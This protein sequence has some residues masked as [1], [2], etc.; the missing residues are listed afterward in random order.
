MMTCPPYLVDWTYG[1]A[2]I[3]DG[4]VPVQRCD[5]CRVFDGDEAAATAAMDDLGGTA[6][7]FTFGSPPWVTD[8]S[9]YEPG[10]YWVAGITTGG[11]HA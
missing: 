2:D 8:P 11:Q 3:P 6:V 5:D 7:G 9:E 10:D 1:Y 4:A